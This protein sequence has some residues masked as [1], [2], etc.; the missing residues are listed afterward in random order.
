MINQLEYFIWPVFVIVVWVVAYI[1]WFRPV[2]K[3]IQVITGVDAQLNSPK[4]TAGEKLILWL[5]G[6][7]TVIASF[8]TALFSLACATMNVLS[9]NTDM[10]DSLKTDIPW[11]SVITPVNGLRIVAL[12]TLV[13]TALHLYGKLTAAKA[14]P[15][16]T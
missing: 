4:N 8:F 9:N 7:K 15:L 11:A 16:A 10:L 14:I 13:I 3:K 1:F 5:D 12:F 6:M 2:V